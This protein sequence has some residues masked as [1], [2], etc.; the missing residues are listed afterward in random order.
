MH[1]EGI[2]VI[3]KRYRRRAGRWR[4][5]E[6]TRTV[7]RKG[8]RKLGETGTPRVGRRVVINT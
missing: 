1:G 8:K 5:V 7:E 6:T 4:R 2:L 3:V